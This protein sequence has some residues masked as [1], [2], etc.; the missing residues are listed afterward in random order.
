MSRKSIVAILGVI[1]IFLK[2]QFGLALDATAFIGV[3]LY[4]LFEAKLDAKRIASQLGRFK[5]PKFYVALVTAVIP[6]L[7]AEFGWNLPLD[8]IL[9]VLNLLLAI[10]FGKDY[11][12][13]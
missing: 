1:L 7:N 9:I 6:A 10:L 13:A 5:D 4:L 12:N 11:K 2:E 3:I 8:V